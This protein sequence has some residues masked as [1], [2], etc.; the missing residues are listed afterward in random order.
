MVICR[1]KQ[2]TSAWKL[3]KSVDAHVSCG[4][5]TTSTR[6]GS[7]NDDMKEDRS[8]RHNHQ[9]REAQKY[10]ESIQNDMTISGPRLKKTTQS[11]V[12]N[13]LTISDPELKKTLSQDNRSSN[14]R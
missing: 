4:G 12:Q 6:I 3:T 10:F 14:A 7:V 2:V 1:A 11:I 8:K 13:D 9:W 5:A